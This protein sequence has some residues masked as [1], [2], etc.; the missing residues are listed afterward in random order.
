[1]LRE[2]L[3]K[4]EPC[5]E[6]ENRD[7]CMMLH[8]M[9]ICSDYLFRTNE[10]AHFTASAW[11]V[12]QDRS[13]VLLIYHNI[14]NSW[15]WTGGHADGEENLLQTAL[16]EAEEETGLQNL[17]AVSDDIFSIE[18]IPVSG[19]VKRGRYVSSHLH[20]NVT[21]LV[22]ADENE[23]PR[24]KEDE[25]SDIGWFEPERLELLSDEKWMKEIV[26]A[27]LQSKLEGR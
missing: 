13:K 11:I 3:E 1:M 5:N 9:D 10:I 16:R 21:Y 2:Q 4:Y 12:N 23:I 24:V 27:K 20:L 6:Q 26:Y 25:N 15:T 14:Y 19:H 8:I 22:Q 7:K 17:K 18:I